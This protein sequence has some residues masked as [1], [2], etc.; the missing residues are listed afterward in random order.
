[1]Y[2]IKYYIILKCNQEHTYI[3]DP[4]VPSESHPTE[5]IGLPKS[6]LN[7]FIKEV[8]QQNKVKGDKSIYTL[9]DKITIR[10]VKYVSTLGCQICATKGKKTLNIE[11]IL[12]ALKTM[13]FTK[14][15]K[16]LTKEPYLKEM[17]KDDE[18]EDF[19]YEDNMN[20]KQ[21]INKK[22]KRQKK[23]KKQFP[24]E[25]DYEK[26]ASEQKHMFEMAKQEQMNQMMRFGST[27][28]ASGNMIM[29]Q[30]SEGNINL[31]Q[32]ISNEEIEKDMFKNEHNGDEEVDFD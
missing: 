12:E 28:F 14:H 22:K 17:E 21:L 27:E 25:E 32:H 7:N 5:E 13:N 31:N 18:V 4:S 23:N 11:H 8:L 2:G 19:R 3:M 16:S 9:L 30:Q 10:Y 29:K 20:V 1:M 24:S 15:I 6:T 26:M